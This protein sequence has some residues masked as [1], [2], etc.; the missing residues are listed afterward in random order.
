[1][2]I[3]EY[4]PIRA[5]YLDPDQPLSGGVINT[6][7]AYALLTDEVDAIILEL[8]PWI[9]GHEIDAVD[10]NGIYE[11]QKRQRHIHGM[12]TRFSD[13]T[14]GQFM[15]PMVRAAGHVIGGCRYDHAHPPE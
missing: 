12:G 11:L 1:M 14:A 10:R 4:G 3:G 8:R 15:G 5:G 7:R 13:R 6:D 2:Q 9:F